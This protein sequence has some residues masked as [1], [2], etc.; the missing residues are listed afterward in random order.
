[1]G[2]DL[3]RYRPQPEHLAELAQ[4]KVSGVSCDR[5]E[6]GSYCYFQMMCMHSFFMGICMHSTFGEHYKQQ[7]SLHS[8]NPVTR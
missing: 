2:A 7:N 3:V 5:I 1:M 8:F 4:L 6:G